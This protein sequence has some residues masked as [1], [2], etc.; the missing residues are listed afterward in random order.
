MTDALAS[1]KNFYSE[2]QGL[3]VATIICGD[4]NAC[5]RG[6]IYEYMR[7]GKFDCLKLD[8]YSMSGQMYAQ[9]DIK[10]ETPTFTLMSSS[11]N[12]TQA[13]K[14]PENWDDR[15]TQTLSNWYTEISNTSPHL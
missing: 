9:Y 15:D 1:L 7:S 2:I 12:V 14:L 13:P 5:P 6:G 4:F 10:D 11:M 8:K 3:K